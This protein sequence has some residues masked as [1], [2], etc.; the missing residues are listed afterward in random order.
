MAIRFPPSVLLPDFRVSL[1]TA[2]LGTSRVRILEANPNRVCLAFLPRSGGTVVV[3]PDA[4]VTTTEGYQVNFAQSPWFIDF[5]TVGP[6]VGYEWWGIASVASFPIK[7]YEII[8]QP[9]AK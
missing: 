3:S 7:F 6:L 1:R 9:K 8:Y 5:G 4:G 2:T